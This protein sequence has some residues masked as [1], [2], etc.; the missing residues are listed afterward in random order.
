MT[1]TATSTQLPEVLRRLLEATARG[2]ISAL[3]ELVH[4]DI[5]VEWP[6]SGE[7]FTGRENAL[8]AQLATPVKPEMAGEP[9]VL[10][11]GD[12]WIVR[13]P[14]RYGSETHYYAGIFEIED[15]RLRRTTEYFAAP[16]PPN[17]ARARFADR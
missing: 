15:G 14:L 7:R 1:T 8:G 3:T 6:Q 9:I 11:S 17:E 2:D 5:S 12:V 4:P 13:M 10:G 16:F